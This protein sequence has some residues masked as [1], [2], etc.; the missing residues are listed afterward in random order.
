MN[1]FRAFILGLDS[2][3]ESQNQHEQAALPA[4]ENDDLAAKLHRH[5]VY[6]PKTLQA[7]VNRE[8]NNKTFLIEGLLRSRSLNV[9]VGDSGLGKTPLGVQLG[10]CV[11]TGVPFVG[12]NVVSPGA[13]LYCDAESD[14]SAF[15]STVAAISR[16]LGIHPPENFHVWSPN[17]ESSTRKR[18]DVFASWADQ[19]TT[20]VELLRPALV[21]VDPLRMFWPEAEGKNKDTAAVITTLRHLSHEVKCSWLITHHRRK[22]NQQ[23][24]PVHLDQDLH[25]WFQEAAGAHAI[26]NNSDTR[27][28]VTSHPRS[29]DL[30]VAG[31][32]R[33]LGPFAPLDLARVSDDEGN[34]IGYR[35]LTGVALLNP[36]DQALYQS[37]NDQFRFKD[38][39]A[40]MAGNSD[41]NATRFL[42]KA[43]LLGILTKERGEYVKRLPVVEPVE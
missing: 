22:T 17:W 9:L 14:S 42:K 19:L 10:L 13:V 40:R 18:Q 11:A 33:G 5:G 36:E 12:L 28:G 15:D 2:A 26:V 32:T 4:G 27:M 1:S 30:L 6:T 38:V 39:R 35:Q 24:G 16:F 37:L 3:S 7:M 34:P 23:V 31:F 25:A 43:C 41:S 20:R 8:S 21:I 29:A